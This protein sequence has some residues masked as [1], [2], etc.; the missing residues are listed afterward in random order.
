MSF[1]FLP[2]SLTKISGSVRCGLMLRRSVRTLLCV[3]ALLLMAVN[4]PAPLVYR[5]GEGWSYESVGGGKWTRTRAKDQLEVAQQA[6]D[7]KNYGTALKA[8]RRTVRTWPLSDYAPQAQYLVG[9][10]L[11]EEKKDEEAFKAYQQ[12]L[13][14]YPK[15]S[16]YEDVVKRQYEIA[17]RYLAGQWFK[18]WGYI[19]FFP[20][21]DK[22]VAMYEKL[23]KNGPYSQVAPTAQMNIGA[24]REKQSDFPAAVKAYENA[25]DKYHDRKQVA[26]DAL[27]K[28]AEAYLKQ[29]KTA[30]YDQ[31]VAGQAIATFTDFMT[32][33]PADPRVPEAQKKIADLRTEQARGSLI[34]ARFYEKKKQW[35]GAL[36]YYNEVL[37]RDPQSKYAEEARRRID[38]IKKRTVRQTA[39][40]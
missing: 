26:A 18:L 1:S 21:M 33:Y 11:E 34:V 31:S 10:C 6:F 16:N 17:N 30:E 14:R 15:S 9:R 37:I 7:Q 36:V 25:A 19:P 28:A 24:A 3:S 29:A 13:E 32:L 12:L 4:T 8:A 27:Y 23:I 40:N 22:T 35:D 39:Q 5:P 2:S 20:S 38:E